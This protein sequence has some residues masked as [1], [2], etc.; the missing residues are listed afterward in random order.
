MA[1]AGQGRSRAFAA[2]VALVAFAGVAGQFRSTLAN[3][4]SV[5]GAIWVL[6]RYFTIIANLIVAVVFAE[7]ALTN[8]APKRP[9]L[10]G[11]AVIS[12]GL[13]GVVYMLLLR[14]LL[15]LSGGQALADF[16]L[17]YVSPV[18]APAWW[19]LCAPKGGLR[20][21][22][23]LIWCAL[24]LGY[25]IYAIVRGAIDG[26]YAYPFLNIGE[27]GLAT[28]ATTCAVIAVGYLVGACA[29]VTLDG[30]LGRRKRR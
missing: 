15:E 26:I 24:P 18:L 30:L 16:L 19:L 17:H 2:F 20:Y 25:V 13:V 14:G 21:R 1:R 10:L 7:R 28:V 22:D 3:V 12:I 9:W 27:R 23:T 8:G 6:L 4:G 11:G 29:F 5:G